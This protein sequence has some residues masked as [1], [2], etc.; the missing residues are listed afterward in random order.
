MDNTLAH[1]ELIE[2]IAGYW[3]QHIHDLEIASYP[4]GSAEFFQELDAYRYE[5]LDYLP[6]V[7]DFASF[8]GLRLLEVGCGVGIDLVRMA[9]AGALVTG[10]DLAD[11]SIQLARQ[12]MA[13]NGLPGDLRLMDGERLG[14]QDGSFDVVYAHGV[15]QYTAD[16]ERMIHEIHRVLRPGGKAV[17]MVYNRYSW[18]NA[19]SKVMKVGLEHEDAPVLRKFSIAEFRR[20]LGLFDRSEIIPERFP[21]RTRLHRGWKAVLYNRV[22]VSSFACLPRSWVRSLGW[23][24][25][26]IGYKGD[27]L[28]SGAR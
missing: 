18:L 2:E 8:R 19:L 5:K 23:H 9:R 3:N 25:I 21:V 24:L 4:V 7:V 16:P 1:Q 26:G 6:R 15:L 27:P 17:L 28:A 11:V 13:Q 20:M 14:F 22:F 10:V 12:N